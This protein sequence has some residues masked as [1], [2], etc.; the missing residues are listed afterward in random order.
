M[1][2]QRS[3]RSISKF[4]ATKPRCK[5]MPVNGGGDV[6]LRTIPQE[7]P[8]PEVLITVVSRQSTVDRPVVSSPPT[9]RK[10]LRSTPWLGG[11]VRRASVPTQDDGEGGY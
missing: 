2:R 7:G 11:T 10:L 9:G 3:E 4:T 1:D 8:H 6:L 5:S